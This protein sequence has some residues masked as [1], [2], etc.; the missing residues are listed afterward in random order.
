MSSSGSIVT[1]TSTK[2]LLKYVKLEFRMLKQLAVTLRIATLAIL[3][4]FPTTFAIF[5]NA[6]PS[7]TP[8]LPQQ[9]ESLQSDALWNSNIT[10]ELFD[11]LKE[12]A[13]IADIS[14]CAGTYG[15]SKPFVCTTHCKEFPNVELVETFH[16]SY[17]PY[18]DCGFIAIDHGSG[19]NDG[20][21]LVVFRG[22]HSITDVITDLLMVPQEYIPYSLHPEDENVESQSN[23]LLQPLYDVIQR[24]LLRIIRRFSRGLS[25]ARQDHRNYYTSKCTNCTVHLG[26][27]KSYKMI[28]HLILTNISSAQKKYPEY[29]LN[30]V[31]HSLGGAVAAL[32]ALELDS[33]GYSPLV[34]TFGEP[35]LGNYGLRDYIDTT[36]NL[37]SENSKSRTGFPSSKSRYR[38][39]T[40]INDPFPLL[41]T[42]NFNYRPHAGEIFISKRKAPQTV[43]DLRLC[44]GDDDVNCIAGENTSE[45]LK[46]LSETLRAEAKTRDSSTANGINELKKRGKNGILIPN[47]LQLYLSHIDYFTRMDL[48]LLP[49]GSPI[50][51]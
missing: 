42:D 30:L 8:R 26:F 50:D 15:I 2:Y 29:Q 16:S 27:W 20:R 9:Q 6:H 46:L 41:P 1:S 40:H 21:I 45:T 39:V 12:L 13:R 18:G 5:A 35:R 3:L 48:C 51:L 47:L 10:Q 31:G 37:G 33:L 7:P 23:F 43:E 14:Y 28:R 25:R 24:P 49:G 19:Q 11:E 4:L 34:T 36:F 22:T 17:S 38:R 32:A 44:F